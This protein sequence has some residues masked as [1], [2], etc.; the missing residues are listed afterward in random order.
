MTA[1]PLG[2]ALDT[3]E[4]LAEGPLLPEVAA[5]VSGLWERVYVA[6]EKLRGEVVAMPEGGMLA[7][8]LDVI[9][10]GRGGQYPVLF[11]GAHWRLFVSPWH[12]R[13]KLILG[14]EYLARVDGTD[15]RL[16]C[17]RIARWL[18][19]D[20]VVWRVSR[21][22]VCCDVAGLEV[23]PFADMDAIV[24]TARAASVVYDD[25]EKL[26]DVPLDALAPRLRMR[27]REVQTVSFGAA[28]GRLACCIYDKR[29]EARAKDRDW[30]LDAA[31]ERGWD[32]LEPLTRVEFR[33]RGRGLDE[34]PELALRGLDVLDRVAAWAPRVW[35]YATTRAVRFMVPDPCDSNRSRWREV[36]AEWLIVASASEAAEPVVRVRSVAESVRTERL[37]RASRDVM[38]GAVALVAERPQ[39]A[40]ESLVRLASVVDGSSCDVPEF[41]VLA[42]ALAAHGDLIGR[43]VFGDHDAPERASALRSV[44][45]SKARAR[46]YHDDPGL[47]ASA[48]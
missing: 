13:A 27:A 23:A 26:D 12:G 11:V 10:S 25:G 33:V 20:A 22:D 9:A 30:Q 16:E 35:R 8:S 28:A 38:R 3:L 43:R 40:H 14:A 42:V 15:A 4:A 48:A 5:L 7:P 44:V 36:T 19:G 31:R 6:G 45:Q 21:L 47:A 37:R 46:G 18:W 39:N 29:A 34:F 2:L 24:T 17:E 41:V 1:R 32:G